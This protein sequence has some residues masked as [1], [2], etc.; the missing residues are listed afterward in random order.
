VDFTIAAIGFAS[1]AWLAKQLN[2]G[3]ITT[4][5][6]RVGHDVIVFKILS[7]ATALAYASVS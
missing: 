1:V 3:F 6:T 4:A 2:I 7:T 5:T